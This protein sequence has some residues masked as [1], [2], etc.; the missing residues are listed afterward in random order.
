MKT[1]MYVYGHF[2]SCAYRLSQMSITYITSL[3]RS[4][5]FILDYFFPHLHTLLRQLPSTRM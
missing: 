5:Y 1:S 2:G 4:L 3:L